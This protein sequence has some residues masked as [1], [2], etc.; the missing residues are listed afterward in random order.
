M[1]IVWNIDSSSDAHAI[2]LS[3]HCASLLNVESDMKTTEELFRT[4]FEG[5]YDDE[6]AWDAVSSLRRRN[7]DEVFQSAVEYSDSKAPKQRARA[8][9]VL[10]QLGSGEPRSERPHFDECVTIALSHLNEEDPMVVHSAAWALA[11][12][13]DDTAVSALIDM[14]K[15]SDPDVRWA[16]A[17]GMANRDHPEAISTLIELME[18]SDD[19]VRNWST[20]Q[21]AGA[22]VGDGAGR[23][24]PL[25]DSPEIRAALRKRLN[26]SFADVRAEAVWGLA[27]RRDPA[28]L[29]LLLERLSSEP[30]WAGDEMAAAEILDQEYDTPVESLR[31]GVQRLLEI[32]GK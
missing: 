1:K 21:L 9:D 14:R 2:I 22:Y 32:T 4:S 13:N 20:F 17:V 25:L 18:D 12:L 30:R 29:E 3:Q 26:D 31:S 11:H 10:A 5:D 27:Q 15:H 7:T 6:A 28:G 24:C 16:V 23:I 19:E 8:L